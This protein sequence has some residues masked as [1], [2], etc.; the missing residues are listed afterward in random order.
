MNRPE[1]GG[2]HGNRGEGGERK[3]KKNPSCMVDQSE[4]REQGR[5]V[6]FFPL[7]LFLSLSKPTTHPDTVT[8]PAISLNFRAM[9]GGGGAG[10]ATG[11]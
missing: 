4:E 7:S 6:K 5:K 9:A 1:K 3:G 2:S 8:H 10:G 11:R